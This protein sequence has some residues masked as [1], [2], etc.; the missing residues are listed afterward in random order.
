MYSDDEKSLS[1]VSERR[2][3]SEFYSKSFYK[4]VLPGTRT[5]GLVSL[6]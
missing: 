3:D 4:I 2:G 5:Y 1:P 6:L